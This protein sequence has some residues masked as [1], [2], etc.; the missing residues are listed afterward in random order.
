VRNPIRTSTVRQS[1]STEAAASSLRVRQIRW[2]DSG[3]GRRTSRGSQHNT[4]STYVGGTAQVLVLLA[5]DQ[6]GGLLLDGLHHLWMAVA[7]R[8]RSDA[9]TKDAMR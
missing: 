4:C 1:K 3:V 9:C 6:S 8:Q 5:L 7:C 2:I